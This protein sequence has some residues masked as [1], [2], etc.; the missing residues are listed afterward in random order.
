MSVAA[1]CRGLRSGNPV[2]A[3]FTILELW[4]VVLT[5]TLLATVF[6]PALA[7]TRTPSKSIRCLANLRRFTA[8]WTMYSG[9]FNDRVANNFGAAETLQA[10]QTGRL[11]NWANNI[12]TWGASASTEDLSNTNADWLA[13]GV[14]GPYLSGA[15]E[16]YKCP[17]DKY[18]S[19]AQ[20]ARGWAARTRSISMNSVFG[21]FG[22]GVDSTAQGLNWAF[23]SYVQY[24]TQARVPKP[25]KTWLV[26]DE[27]P[28]SINDGYFLNSPQAT[29]WQDIPA[30]FHNDATGISF[31]D[32]H[33][34]MKRWQSATS[35]YALVR[36][37]YPTTRIFDTL[38]RADFAWYLE[39]TGY[40][41]AKTGLGAFN[42]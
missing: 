29:N 3:A 40:V 21:R 10:I 11:G 6:T 16:T 13:K 23:P 42:Y 12:M 31:S 18:L 26:L 41:D 7:R 30:P 8:A 17:S 32:G 22:T 33:A 24:L 15:L 25:A 37:A 34:E 27:H 36:F 2:R 4:I 14:L 39:H 19:R 38:G 20:L 5:L 28:D 9:D 35:K 1:K